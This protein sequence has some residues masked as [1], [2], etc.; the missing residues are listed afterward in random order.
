MKAIIIGATGAVGKDLLHKLIGDDRY[1]EI[2][3]LVR[4][5][6]TISHEKLRAHIVDF[7][8]P[9]TWSHL[10]TGDVL[11]A[12]LGTTLKQAGSKEAQW[13]IDHGYTLDAARAA[14]DNGVPHVVLVTSAGADHTSSIFYLRMKG[15]I[16]NDV[17]ALGFPSLTIIRP[18]SLIRPHTDRLGEKI[19]VPLFRFLNIFGIARGMRPISTASVAAAMANVGAETQEGEQMLETDAILNR[20]KQAH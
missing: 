14:H 5:E 2:V 3:A 15:A 1:S 17:R 11:F 10:V 8:S 19:T 4:R 7:E 20:A 18:P 16:E 9:D 6:P 13:R 12:T